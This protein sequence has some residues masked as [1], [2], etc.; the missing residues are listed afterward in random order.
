M[1]FVDMKKKSP[2]LL[3]R[4]G[5][6]VAD[7]NPA[8][9]ASPR[10]PTLRDL[11]VHQLQDLFSAE[12]QLIDALPKMAAAARN[13]AL[14]K[15]ITS[16]LKQTK[17]QLKRLEVIGRRLKEDLNAGT[18]KAT[19][20]LVAEASEWMSESA[21]PEVMDAGIAA[22][23][24]RVEHYEIAGYGTVLAYAKLLGETA[25]ARLL[26]MTLR[27]EEA[28]DKKLGT[29]AQPINRA[30]VKRSRAA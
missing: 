7:L 6:T 20:G 5:Q 24:Q 26:A 8:A 28:A 12:T 2:S 4:I 15:A 17:S 19:K 14:K 27:E 11:F 23:A 9:D 18:C 29:I 30:A 22:D 21:S 10:F 25:A 13:A 1:R 16:H 3:A